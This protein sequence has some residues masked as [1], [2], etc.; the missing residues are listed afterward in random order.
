MPT[1]RFRL[2]TTEAQAYRARLSQL[3]KM[4]I[5]IGHATDP[6]PE[7]DRLELKQTQN[8][9]ARIYELPMGEVGVVVPAEMTILK[10]GILITNVAMMIPGDDCPID[11]WD[12]EENLDYFYKELIGQLYHS[13]PRLLYP[14]LKRE[15][16]LNVCKVEGVIIAHGSSSIFSKYHDHSPIPVQLLLEDERDNELSFDFGVEVDRSLMHEWERRRRERPAFAPINRTGMFGPARRQ[17][18][19]QKKASREGTIPRVDARGEHDTT[20][21]A[22]TPKPS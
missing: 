4:D 3:A 22:R 16:P 8:D 15:L 14:Y 18:G 9:F 7:H 13:P 1:Q 17:P 5:P 11:L 20:Y 19:D 10:S 2:N 12:P 21:D 6:S